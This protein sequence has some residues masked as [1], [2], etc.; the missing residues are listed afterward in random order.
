MQRLWVL[1]HRPGPDG[2][3]CRSSGAYANAGARLKPW[4]SDFDADAK[5]N[6]IIDGIVSLSGPRHTDIT[7]DAAYVVT[8]L[9]V[10]LKRVDAGWR[11]TG[12]AWAKQ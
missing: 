2:Y 4:M 12:W 9:A 7:G 6:E 10:A 1:L 8:S 3:S 11:I 5:E